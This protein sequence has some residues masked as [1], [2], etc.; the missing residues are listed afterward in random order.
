MS[1]APNPEVIMYLQETNEYGSDYIILSFSTVDRSVEDK[2]LHEYEI[3]PEQNAL[4]EI[5]LRAFVYASTGS[6]NRLIGFDNVQC[7][8]H[9]PTVREIEKLISP[10]KRLD[11]AMS[12]ARNDAED[13]SFTTSVIALAKAAKVRRIKYRPLGKKG[14]D[15]EVIQ[16]NGCR[17]RLAEIEAAMCNKFTRMFA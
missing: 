14:S 13:Y 8:K 3:T 15:L 17:P 1:M 2:F 10:M 7:A 6:P 11:K 9:L 16:V 5:T 4:S 12:K